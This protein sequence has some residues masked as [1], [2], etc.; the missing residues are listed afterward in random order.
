MILE[1]KELEIELALEGVIQ[2]ETFRL[3]QEL[4]SHAFLTMKLLVDGEQAEN[5]VNMASILPVIIR[6]TKCTGG[7]VI[8][9]GK[10]ETVYTKVEKGLP[11]L[12]LE[13]YSYTKDWER[14]EKSRSFL[15]GP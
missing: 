3:T 15:N 4:N 10:M 13:A 7:R 5:F 8:F 6:E 11:F 1:Y 2:V 12:Y 9:Q 14:T